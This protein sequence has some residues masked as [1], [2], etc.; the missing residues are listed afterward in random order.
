MSNSNKSGSS[1]SPS[2]RELISDA[3]AMARSGKQGGKAP[4]TRQLVNDAE[5]MLGRKSKSSAPLIIGAVLAIAAVGIAV[6][7]L[8]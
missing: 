3:E 5:R 2:T 7:F 8:L 4:S 1:G 6:V